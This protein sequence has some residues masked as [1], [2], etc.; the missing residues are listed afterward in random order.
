[1][2]GCPHLGQRSSKSVRCRVQANDQGSRHEICQRP[3]DS[4]RQP[5][6]QRVV[7][8]VCRQ[9]GGRMRRRVG[10]SMVTATPSQGSS[11]IAMSPS[12]A[13][14]V[15]SASTCRS[16]SVKQRIMWLGRAPCRPTKLR[17]C[18]TS[19]RTRAGST[20]LASCRGLRPQPGGPRVGFARRAHPD[21]LPTKFAEG[22]TYGSAHSRTIS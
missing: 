2:G 11:V 9:F 12:G 18:E 7:L 14:P 15:R 22:K 10:R 4:L 5:G 3:P 17:N 6:Q 19:V 8:P 20:P 1:M 21:T 13:S 16:R